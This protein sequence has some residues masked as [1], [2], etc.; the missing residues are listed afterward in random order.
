MATEFQ[1]FPGLDY[2]LLRR[3]HEGVVIIR[4]LELDTFASR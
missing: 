4:E 1:F 2:T 3:D